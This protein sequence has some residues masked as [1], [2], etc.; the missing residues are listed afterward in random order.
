MTT[1]EILWSLLPHPSDD[2][3]VRLFARSG[4][5][6]IGDFAR[7]PGEIDRFIRSA[8]GM[9][10]YVAPNPT[11]CKTGVRHSAKDVTHWS[12]FLL[13]VDP[14]EEDADPARGLDLALDIFGRLTHRDYSEDVPIL[15]DSG[16][17]RQAW[18]RLPDVELADVVPEVIETCEMPVTRKQARKCAG[19]W[20]ARL[21][22]EFGTSFGCR[23]DTT[24][25]DLPRVMR[26]VGTPNKKTGREARFLNATSRV[27]RGLQH[28]LLSGVPYTVYDD[29][30]PGQLPPGTPWQVAFPKLTRKAQDYL[31][32]GKQEP[33]RHQTAWH[34]AQKL[35]ESGISP[36][37]TTAALAWGN[38]LMGSDNELSSQDL[39]TI[40]R[41]VYKDVDL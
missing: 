34:V 7:S 25:S 41:Q 30:E 29:P 38:G 2:H 5:T 26:L 18:F 19:W 1:S 39:V 9:N 12:Y 16:R 13:D 23:L 40:V 14:V 4:D 10:C 35:M 3:V 11:T 27:Y 15:I 21:S 32:K 36:E 33:G 8:P 20:L 6:R 31:T 22:E 17:G 37:Q 28:T 24:V